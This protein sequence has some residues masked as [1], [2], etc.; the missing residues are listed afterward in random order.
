MSTT[1][2]PRAGMRTPPLAL[3]RTLR[4]TAL[5]T[6][7][8]LGLGLLTAPVSSAA[9][10]PRPTSHG[11]AGGVPPLVP[12][13][14]SPHRTAAQ[15]AMLDAV[16]KA[17]STGEPVVV[18]AMTDEA[19]RT[20]ANPAGTLTTTD[21]A[22]P[23]RTK[24]DGAWVDLDAAL[25]P[26]ADG[27]VGPALTS[28]PVAF[29]GGGSG[30]MATV[31][32]ADGKKL[33]VDA[34]FP[35]PRPTLNGAT[36]TYQNVLPDVDLQLTAL[37]VGGWRDVIVVHTAQ[38]AENPAL[39]T[40]RFP[41]TAQGLTVTSDERGGIDVKDDKGALRFRSPA[42]LQWDSSR[43]AAGPGATA[44]V[45]A[46]FASSAVTTANDARPTDG[47]AST[48]EAPG[49][50]AKVAVIGS[51]VFNGA[52][53]LTPDQEALGSG[54]GPWYLDPTL[55]A[56]TSAVEGS[57]QVQ[58]NYK[59]V[60]NYNKKS[61]L[62]TG[63]CGYR[64]SDPALDCKVQGRE[65]AY[66]QF[67]VNPAIHTKVPGAEYPPTLFTSTLNGQVSGA[68]SPGTPTDLGVYWAPR[69]IGE[70]T[71]WNNQPCGTNG[72]VV[73]EG[74]SYVGGQ[75]ITGTGPLAVD[76]TDIM[77]QA[78]AGTWST[79]TIGIAPM[80]TE[81]EKLYRHAIAS[82][83]SITTTYDIAPTVWYPRTSP[84]PGFA[85]SNSTAECTSGGANPWDNP[86]W[87]GNNLNLYLTV[88]SWS[89]AGQNVY[90]GY[91]LWDDND[92]DFRIEQGS[93]GGA[94]NNPGPSLSVGSL[95]DGHQYGWLA[96]ATDT[97]LT[98]PNSAWCYFRVD[99][100]NPRLSIASS[101][102]PPSGTPNDH[103]ARYAGD[104]GSFF[105]NAED[106][107]PG[108]GLQASG[109]ACVR[110]S[111]DPTPV[112]GWQCGQPGTYGPGAQVPFTP[113]NWGTNI[114]YAW[115]MDNAGNFSQ[116][117]SYSFYA[118]WKPGT[119][120]VF[121]DVD[122]D[123]KPDIVASDAKGDLRIIGGTTDPVNSA[124][125]PAAAAPGNRQFGASWAD[126]QISHHGTL[127]A[128]QAVDQIV[129]HY[130]KESPSEL[131][132]ALYL[133]HN[134]GTGR[135]DQLKAGALTRPA[136]CTVYGSE[137]ACPDYAASGWSRV[138]QAAAIGTP[139]G[140][141]VGGSPADPARTIIMSQTSIL[142]L[143]QNSLY[144]FQADGLADDLLTATQIPTTSGSWADYELLSPGA[145]NGASVKPGTTTPVNQ[146]TVWAR[147]RT[148]GNIYSYALGWNADG[149]VDYSSL[150]RPDNGFLILSGAD[151]TTA[152]QPQVGAG[153]LNNDGF[154]DVWAIDNNQVIT[155][156]PGR[157]SD[158]TKNKVDGFSPLQYL[159][160]ANAAVSIRSNRVSSRCVDA[161]G[162]PHDGATVALW[163]CW[164]TASQR[165]NFATDGTVRAGGY[166][167]S[168]KDGGLGDGT[169]VVLARC[170]DGKGQKWAMRPDG[171]LFLPA[172]VDGDHPAGRCLE[173]PG[174]VTEPGTRLDIYECP[175]LQDNQQWSLVP[176]R[177]P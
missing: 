99:R 98:S 141:A 111:A 105:V 160:H 15:Q 86:G 129:A 10:V 113:R 19:S 162:G 66:F 9:D 83:P 132:N 27:T 25:R 16:A 62:S 84:A 104:S 171:R 82:N 50:G 148:N 124:A 95:A 120:P 102:F 54:A 88:N 167:L 151:W 85:S 109:V 13:A 121:G 38:A 101:D 36:A 22:Q 164:E 145:A 72:N 35:L 149:S 65:R 176:E 146:T 8:L 77:K 106:P 97:L 93:W 41:L 44:P 118:P 170:E 115:A 172:T 168:T 64:S 6:S 28:L 114:V 11:P 91:I 137:T 152:A 165:F 68:S 150:T 24:H 159:G 78:A 87:V 20:V 163:G 153:D 143:E 70:P 123:Q 94:Q 12:P 158:G 45:K 155:V 21:N 125:A 92:P 61:N 74:C 112:V 55:T 90:T 135:F 103:P 144:V 7:C 154:P 71:T 33:A 43:P 130:T 51:K 59:D 53:E 32:T 134:D 116:P 2:R 79:W 5:G 117:A 80:A 100:T 56:V 26:N 173:L 131:K 73:M 23:V 17:R 58:E 161:E 133:V 49:D 31:S 37:S 47:T 110:F 136:N 142:T 52:I 177:T 67:K 156:Y 119:Q 29:S 140:E 14:T 4:L 81:W 89:P 169:A 157:S 18:E 42:P 39:K 107:A 108:N 3:R 63:F 46:A 75:K 174:W 34:P 1:S 60:A 76:V 139:E 57:V 147:H 138:S 126:F 122:N 30:P 166:C 69:G 96:R 128:G 127:A 175:G 40:L 48:A